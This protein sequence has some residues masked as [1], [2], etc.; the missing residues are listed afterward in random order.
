MA[1]LPAFDAAAAADVL[2]RF[3]ASYARRGG[4]GGFVL[5]LS[6]GVDSAVVAG[7]AA[8][9]V[10]PENVLGLVLPHRESDPTDAAHARLVAERLGVATET[11]DVTPVVEA[12]RAGCGHAFEGVALGNLKARARML[13]LYAH[14]NAAGRLVLGTGN[15]SELLQGYFTKYGDGAADVYPIGDV[16][17]TNVWDLARHLGVPE[18]VVAKPPSAG[19][20]PGQTDEAEMGVR[21]KDLDEVLAGLEAVSYTHLTLPTTERV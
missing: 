11:V 3:L 5:G 17:K 16:Y 10:G 18:P 12:V 8:R 4:V 14:A 21:Y 13:V 15:K 1:Y 19:L 20:H 6:G 2:A 7:L 9:A